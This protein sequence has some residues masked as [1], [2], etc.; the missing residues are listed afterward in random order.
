MHVVFVWSEQRTFSFTSCRLAAQVT[1]TRIGGSKSIP[2]ME[3][4]EPRTG[5]EPPA[6]EPA[7]TEMRDC[8]PLLPVSIAGGEGLSE[9]IIFGGRP[10]ERP[11]P[12]SPAFFPGSALSID[13]TR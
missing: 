12:P 9:A 5:Y 11:P 3:A 4:F 10:E 7:D 6:L 1:G 2:A 8:E 13:G